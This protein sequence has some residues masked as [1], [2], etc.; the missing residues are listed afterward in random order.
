MIILGEPYDNPQEAIRLG[1]LVGIIDGEGYIRVNKVT[2]PSTLKQRKAEHLGAV[3]GPVIGVGMVDRRPPELLQ[4]R[5]GGSLREECVRDRRSIWRWTITSRKDALRALETLAPLLIVKR[6]QAE[7]LLA[8]CQHVPAYKGG[9]GARR[10]HI[11]PHELQRREDA[12]Q[13]LR[14]LNHWSTCND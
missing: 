10:K 14:K 12:Y 5:F 6:K 3:Y 13:R 8:F 11:P 9:S 4:E 7:E 2:A 1:Y